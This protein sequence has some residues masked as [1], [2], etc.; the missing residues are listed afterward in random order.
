MTPGHARR[1]FSF[2]VALQGALALAITIAA[3]ADAAP[4][5]VVWG[6]GASFI[7][8]AGTL[9][10]LYAN[11]RTVGPSS[12][13][14]AAL[15]LGLPFLFA[16]PVLSDDLYRYLWEGRL[17]LQGFDPYRFAPAD[18]VLS[19]LR[20]SVWSH[21][22]NPELASIY[23]PLSQV[24]FVLAVWMGGQIWTVKLVALLGHVLGTVVVGRVSEPRAAWALGLNPLL[25]GESALNGHLD[26]L[27][28]TALLLSA[29][30]LSR[31]RYVRAGLSVCAAVGLKVVGVVLL[32]LLLRRPRVFVTSVAVSALF[33]LPLVRRALADPASGLGQYAA[34]WQGNESAFALLDSAMQLLMG[35]ERGALTAR[36]LAVA[37]LVGLVSVSLRR[38]SPPLDAARAWIWG[39][40]LLSPQVHPWYLGWLIPLEVAARG[41]AGL[42]WSFVA[43]LAYAPL[44]RWI[45]EGVWEMPL[46]LRVLEYAAVFLSLG[47]DPR[48]P[49]LSESGGPSEK[50]SIPV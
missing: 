16:P 28:G 49:R 6:L 32:P 11:G 12:A 10:G 21:V 34:R 37:L 36:A 40:L 41:R 26:V 27:V 39:V 17:W 20:D 42:V 23:P 8:Y 5:I 14:I 29:W 18:P 19:S 38:R 9:F 31:Q 47:L 48:R 22:N 25:L 43:L 7:G 30:L 13:A 3:R 35:P 2:S 33:L 46:G 24:I 50:A 45:A 44:D 1:L 4:S 15:A